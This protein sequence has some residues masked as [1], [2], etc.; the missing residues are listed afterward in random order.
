M[1]GTLKR[2]LL[3]FI[4]LSKYGSV[5]SSNGETPLVVLVDIVNAG[6]MDICEYPATAL[7]AGLMVTE[8]ISPPRAVNALPI[9]TDLAVPS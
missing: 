3:L 8:P 4:C 7:P 5:P 1:F 2:D 6:V 9:A